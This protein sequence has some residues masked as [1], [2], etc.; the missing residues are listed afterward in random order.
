RLAGAAAFDSTCDLA[1]QCAYLSTRPAAHGSDP[2]A[3]AA[4]MIEEVNARPGTIKGFRQS[5]TFFNARL[6]RHMTIGELLEKVP[7]NKALWDERSPMSY[8]DTLAGLS[9]PLRIYWSS[10]D[11]TVGNQG[12]NQSGKLYRTIKA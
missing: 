3:V 9:F 4:R 7:R 10:A 11:T 6:R 1:T 12:P 2:P 5:A 8:V